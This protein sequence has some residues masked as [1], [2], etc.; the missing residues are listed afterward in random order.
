MVLSLGGVTGPAMNPG[1]DL[2]PRLAF[3]LMP[4]PGKGCSEWHYAWV[5][6]L[7]GLAGGAAAGGLVAAISQLLE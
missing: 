4:I 3:H 7:G 2:G 6:V 5:P 1:R